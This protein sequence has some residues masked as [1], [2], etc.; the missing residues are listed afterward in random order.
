MK[1]NLDFNNLLILKYI[2]AYTLPILKFK[3]T[4]NYIN[5]NF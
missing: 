4:H 1:S 2:N 5:Y 3:N